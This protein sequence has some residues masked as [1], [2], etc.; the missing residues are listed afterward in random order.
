MTWLPGFTRDETIRGAGGGTFVPAAPCG[1]V[2]TTEGG[3]ESAMAVFRS[4]MVAPHVMVDPVT[5]RRAQFIPLDR[6]AYA[7]VNDNGGVETN[8][9]GARQIEVVGYADRTQDMPADQ[10]EWLAVEVLRP[11]SEAVG[12]TGPGLECFGVDAGWVLATPT[13]RQ[14]MSFDAWNRFGGWCGHQHVPENSHW[15]PGALDLPAIVRIAQA[16][17]GFGTM[18][19]DEI[20]QEFANQDDRIVARVRKELEPLRDETRGLHDRTS[21]TRRICRA[22]AHKVGVTQAEIDS[23]A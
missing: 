17:G 16:Q 9:H 8:R 19:D 15:D 20:R 3:W 12:I 10:Q 5:R 6:S 21:L 14:R 4:R 23:Q 1:V 2:H 22:I 18:T 11:I 13:A 7:L